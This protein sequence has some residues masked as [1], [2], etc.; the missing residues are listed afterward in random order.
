MIFDSQDGAFAVLGI[1]FII[2]VG[3]LRLDFSQIA[4]PNPLTAQRT[5]RFRAGRPAIHQYES[6]LA[7]PDAKQNVVSH[8][9]AFAVAGVV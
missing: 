4:R 2:T 7:P 5:R 9:V 1:A 3:E 6:H 8:G